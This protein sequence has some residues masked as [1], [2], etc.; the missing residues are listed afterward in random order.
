M[1]SLVNAVDGRHPLVVAEPTGEGTPWTGGSCDDD[2]R[3]GAFVAHGYVGNFIEG[4]QGMVEHLVSN[5]FVVV[6]PGY[7][8][9]FD[10]PHQYDVVNSGF[11]QGA[12]HS[13]RIDL[14]RI[15]IIGHSFG[16]GMAQWLVQ[17]AEAR[18]W[19]SEAMWVVN[20]APWYSLQVG[21]GEIELPEHTQYTMV[22]YEHD[23]FVD[24][25]IA[26]EIY[27]SLSI[28]ESQRRHVMLLSDYSGKPALEADHLGPVSVEIVGGVG[29]ISTDHFDRWVNYR[30][31]DATAGC[32]LLGEW[33]DH[34]FSDTGAR[35]DGVP[36]KKAIVSHDQHDRGPVALQE[37]TFALVNPRPCP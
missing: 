31:I 29:T 17:Q 2:V 13:G 22:S 36:V 6:F 21:T 9:E 23:Y 16:G 10:P 19:G 32:S 5:G 25:R 1:T 27:D 26:I 33:C 15:G 18:G 35:A 3:P 24:A 30:S 28:P 11:V 37:C 7:T 4:Y 12:E 34:D 8:V 14:D 20:F